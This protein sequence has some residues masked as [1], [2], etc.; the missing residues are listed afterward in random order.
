[1]LPVCGPVR[2]AIRAAVA[3]SPVTRIPL[4]AD[5]YRPCS[6]QAPGYRPGSGPFAPVGT[7]TP[8]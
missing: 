1:M 6:A 7:S 2:S 4:P 3:A 5:P 8:L